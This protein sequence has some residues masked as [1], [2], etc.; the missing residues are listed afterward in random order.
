ML[1]YEIT[2][3]FNKNVELL[4]R[5]NKDIYKLHEVMGMIIEEIPLLPRHENHHLHGEW[6]GCD[7]CHI[8]PNWLLIYEIKPNEN[9][10]I[11]HRT[12]THSDLF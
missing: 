9:K 12:G 6:K 8:E 10:V 2:G 4:R 11:F 7:E 1:N 3:R 5:R